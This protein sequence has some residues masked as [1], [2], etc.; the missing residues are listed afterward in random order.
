MSTA[1]VTGASGFIGGALTKR[2]I[3]EGWTVNALARSE[4]SAKV[5]RDLG[6]TA[7][8]GDLD[9]V[10][11]M[12]EGARGADVA[13][14]CAA[15][16]GEW[17]NAS[18]FERVNVTGTANAVQAAREAGVPRLVH[19][20]TEAALMHG[21][22]LVNVDESAP[23]QPDSKA[24]YSRTKARA[25]QVAR[26]GGAVVIRPRLVWG[27][28]DTTILPALTHAVR[29]GRFAWVEGGRHRTST[30]HVDNVV[31][32]L[33][34]GAQKGAPGEAYFVTDGEPQV[35]RDF[36]TSLLATQGVEVPERSLPRPVA[37][38]VTA[39]GE[40]AWRLLP[41]RGQPPLTSFGF[42]FLSQECTIDISR[43]RRD[44]GY[45]PVTSVPQGMQELRGT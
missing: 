28:G 38:A 19:V 22:P 24:L 4:K 8:K 18:D 14:H 3:A 34:L 12:T 41:L 39:A 1:F 21:Q 32:G 25:E 20:G 45:S 2:L 36:I 17:G 11:A 23:L 40:A 44:L 42:W 13:F 31:E 5:V 29:K 15:H 35:F 26:A 16:L 10:G 27:P 33:L 37:G 9:D 43:A 30:T 7:V 6:A